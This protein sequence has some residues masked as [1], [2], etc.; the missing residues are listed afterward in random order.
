MSILDDRPT[1]DPTGEPPPP[2]E[3]PA[4]RNRESGQTGRT[5]SGVYALVAGLVAVATVIT[6]L[7]IVTLALSACS[8]V[9][10][11]TTSEPQVMAVPSAA[12]GATA[13][14]YGTSTGKR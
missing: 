9:T 1:S 7:G 11:P 10:G 5:S 6:M 13:G 2:R 12:A 3:S 8:D 14:G 4:P